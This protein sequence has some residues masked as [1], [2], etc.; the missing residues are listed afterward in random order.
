MLLL[1]GQYAI[2]NAGAVLNLKYHRVWCPQY[3]RLV[4]V[5]P[6]D[7]RLVQG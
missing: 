4:L 1:M 5:K 3:R 7:Q 2:K 6:V